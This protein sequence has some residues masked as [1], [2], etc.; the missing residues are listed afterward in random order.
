MSVVVGVIPAAGYASRMSGLA[1]SKEMVS[2]GGAPVID[3]LLDRMFHAADEVVVITRPEKED[4]AEHV[5]RRGSRVVEGHPS[6]VSES[7]RLGLH[8]LDACDVVLLGFPDTIWEPEHG[9]VQLVRSLEK[10][11]VALGVFESE[12]PERSDVVTLDGERV[13]SVDVKPTAP[14]STLIWGCAA[15]RTSA[16]A[17]LDRHNEPGYLFDELA[18]EGRGRVRAVPFSGGMIDIGTDEA[19]AQ[20]RTLLGE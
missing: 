6:S 15:A 10:S 19:L 8:G 14:D 12:E 11:E 4:V 20:A 5:R 3:Y 7:L 9:F 13:V 17:G 16:L 2:L 18:G 1:G